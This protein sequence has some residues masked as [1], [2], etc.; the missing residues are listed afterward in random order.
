MSL[1][2]GVRS[3]HDTFCSSGS[4]S[5]HPDHIPSLFLWTNTHIRTSTNALSLSPCFLEVG[6]GGTYGFVKMF[7]SFVI[8]GVKLSQSPSPLSQPQSSRNQNTFSIR[9]LAA[10]SLHNWVGRRRFHI[11][12]F[13][14]SCWISWINCW[15]NNNSANPGVHSIH[16]CFFKS[17]FVLS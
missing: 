16:V 10:P 17:G 1:T 14:I 6:V 9:T 12:P 2:S 3:H 8:S 15:L 4:T 5:Q 11:S 13:F 7:D